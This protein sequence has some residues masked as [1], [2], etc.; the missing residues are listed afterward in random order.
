MGMALSDIVLE[1]KQGLP[2]TEDEVRKILPLFSENISTY[3]NQSTETFV[4]NNAAGY[5]FIHFATHG[6]YNT[7]NHF[8]LIFFSPQVM[9]MTAG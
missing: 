7:N 5:N 8:I 9:R 6:N 2:G 4:K 1:N 3:G